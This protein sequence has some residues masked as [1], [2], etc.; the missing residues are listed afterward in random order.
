[1]AINDANPSYS[2]HFSGFIG[3]QPNIDPS[4]NFLTQIKNQ[5]LIE[6]EVFSI[7]VDTSNG[8]FSSIKFGSYDLHGLADNTPLGMIKTKGTNS[9]EIYISE[10]S[11]GAD[12][13]Q[14]SNSIIF[15]PQL[16]FLYLPHADYD[17][18]RARYF[19]L[20]NSTEIVNDNDKFLYV[21]TDCSNF[22]K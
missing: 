12:Q 16:P 17:T 11:I 3:L 6:N 9:W 7:F 15:E 22:E 13:K 1:M 2:S 5:G 4:E 10:Y 20:Y 8:N 14:I 21:K 18:V 19:E